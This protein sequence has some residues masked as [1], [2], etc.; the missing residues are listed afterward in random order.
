MHIRADGTEYMGSKKIQA[1]ISILQKD[2]INHDSFIVIYTML[3][4][5]LMFLL[6]EWLLLKLSTI[7]HDVRS[8]YTKG[9]RY[10][11]QDK[12]GIITLM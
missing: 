1:S 12:P 10:N 4:Q 2:I 8:A 3:Y 6:I 5:F 11:K 7:D 9:L